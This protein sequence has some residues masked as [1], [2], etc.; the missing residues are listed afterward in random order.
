[1]PILVWV[2]EESRRYASGDGFSVAA[3]KTPF[4]E[5]CDVLSLHV[6]LVEA[7][8]AIVTA[9]D[10]AHMKPGALLSAKVN[11]ELP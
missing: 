10:L 7:T 8:R 3:S 4:F 6:L 2:R 5:S 11:V 1:M 9:A